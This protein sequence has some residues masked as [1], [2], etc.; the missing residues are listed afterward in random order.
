MTIRSGNPVIFGN[1]VEKFLV[2]CVAGSHFNNLF[3]GYFS[4]GQFLSTSKPF[5][6]KPCS[7]FIAFCHSFWM[8]CR[9]MVCSK[10]VTQFGNFII[11]VVLCCSKEKMIRS[12]ASPVVALVKNEKA[13]GNLSK[14]K[15]PSRPMRAAFVLF[16][17]SIFELTIAVRCQRSGP[18]PTVPKLR[19]MWRDW[20]V[21]IYS[22]PKSL[23]DRFCSLLI[24]KV[25]NVH[26]QKSHRPMKVLSARVEP[27]TPDDGENV[28]SSRGLGHN[29]AVE[30]M[31]SAVT[32]AT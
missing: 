7:V 6:M 31:L 21:R 11:R 16:S 3:G 28:L 27:Q 26:K 5:R 17:G 24:G 14:T 2:G 23:F 12:N 22:F 20:A 8:K 4:L 15:Y 29:K 10:A 19:P 1:D 30:M 9:W 18:N 13:V 32:F 25:A